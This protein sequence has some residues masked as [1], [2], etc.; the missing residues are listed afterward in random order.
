[1][2]IRKTEILHLKYLN[3]EWNQVYLPFDLV[4]Q[5]YW[6][7]EL[8]TYVASISE[9]GKWIHKTAGPRIYN[10]F[11]LSNLSALIS[12]SLFDPSIYTIGIPYLTTFFLT[13]IY[14][15]TH[16]FIQKSFDKVMEKRDS[17]SL[18]RIQNHSND[19]NSMPEEHFVESNSYRKPLES[20]GDQEVKQYWVFFR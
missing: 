4:N 7:E 19:F 1:M 11:H 16:H 17:T 15:F 5:T 2:I 6:K 10:H 13:S 8:T 18:S 9:N 14:P 3:L 20:L 12:F